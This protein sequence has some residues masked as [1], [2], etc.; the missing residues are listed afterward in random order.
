MPDRL[1]DATT[2]TLTYTWPIHRE[3]IEL[4]PGNIYPN[5][6]RVLPV[7]KVLEWITRTTRESEVFTLLLF[8]GNHFGR[9]NVPLL[10]YTS[11]YLM[12][13]HLATMQEML[14]RRIYSKRLAYYCIAFSA[15]N[16]P[17]DAIPATLPPKTPAIR[18]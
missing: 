12:P 15:I 3:S 16:L 13:P 11:R 18:T 8:I 6:A 2:L 10:R 14:R 7:T 4:H 1:R 17:Y 9:S 5:E